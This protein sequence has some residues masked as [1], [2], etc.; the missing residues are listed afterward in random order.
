MLNGS[1]LEP[2]TLGWGAKVYR[3]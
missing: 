3:G 2:L 1:V